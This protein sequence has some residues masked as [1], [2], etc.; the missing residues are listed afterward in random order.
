METRLVS[1]EEVSHWAQKGD[2]KEALFVES[3]SVGYTQ[4][5]ASLLCHCLDLRN[6]FVA[7]SLDFFLKGFKIVRNLTNR[8][9]RLDLFRIFAPSFAR[10]SLTLWLK[11]CRRFCSFICFEIFLLFG[12][13]FI[14]SG[15][16]RSRRSAWFKVW[17]WVCCHWFLLRRSYLALFDRNNVL[18]CFS[19]W[20][21]ST[22]R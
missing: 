6:K 5:E 21:L 7:V 22:L 14:G 4:T 19:C 18:R 12:N 2:L 1:V 13:Y 10:L 20:F 8:R 9:V 3:V 11:F 15:R 16:N 17:I